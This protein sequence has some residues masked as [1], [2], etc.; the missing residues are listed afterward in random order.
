MSTEA[1]RLAAVEQRAELVEALVRILRVVRADVEV[2]ADRVRAAGD[3]LEDVRVVGGAL[4][5]GCAAGLFEH[6]GE[7]EVGEAHVERRE[8]GGVD[9]GELAAAVLREGP[10]GLAGLVGVAERRGINW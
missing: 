10:V 1:V 5:V 9:V 8:R 2:V 7:P 3:P 4:R 6:A